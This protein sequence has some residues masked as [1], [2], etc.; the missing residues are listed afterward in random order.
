M[1]PG[2]KVFH[3]PKQNASQAKEMI[4]STDSLESS[5][6]GDALLDQVVVF[7]YRGR[8]HAVDHV[9]LDSSILAE[10]PSRKRL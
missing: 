1:Q 9:S 4:L 6:T 8:F 7:Q 3:V 5:M 2:C 10:P